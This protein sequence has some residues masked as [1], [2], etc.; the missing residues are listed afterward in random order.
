MN[1]NVDVI[2]TAPAREIGVITSEIKILSR[3]FQ[4]TL[5][6]N[7]V[8]IGRRLKEAKASLPYGQWSD[9]LKN[10]VEFSQ[11]SANNFMRL[12]EEYGSSHLS[13][14]PGEDSQTFAN[15]PYSKALQLL[16]IPKDEREAFV[17]E[18]N[19]DELSVSEL[20]QVI[21]ERD[22][23]LAREKELKTTVEDLKNAT[24]AVE[25]KDTELS[26]LRGSL[27][28]LKKQC[29][30]LKANETTLSEKLKAAQNDPK[31][32][33]ATLKKLKN[34]AEEAAKKAADSA[35]KKALEDVQKKLEA[36]E[37]DK[38]AAVFAADQAKQKL[39]EAERKLKTANPEVSAFK[40][41][42]ESMRT[43]AAELQRIIAQIK[44]T[45][46]DTAGKLELALKT[47]VSGFVEDQKG[48]TN[49]IQS[50]H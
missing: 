50:N 2:P 22:E 34:E 3:Q 9:W 18:H 47:F 25:D 6:A 39:D 11:S 26:I 37:A 19:V 12:F 45:D 21:K 44:E 20:K 14:S 36:A 13:L 41:L 16:A 43:T 48:E 23:A 31:I 24:K 10:E 32:P 29:E 8:E 46:S 30:D 7:A 40:A 28:E 17:E 38:A 42:F 1:N 49:A 4:V 5:L 35:S 15:L 33:P 27:S